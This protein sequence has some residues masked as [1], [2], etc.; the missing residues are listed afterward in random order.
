[1]MMKELYDITVLFLRCLR[2]LKKWS[3]ILNLRKNEE[4]SGKMADPESP[5]I[6]YSPRQCIIHHAY[7]SVLHALRPSN[8]IRTN[9]GYDTGTQQKRRRYTAVFD[10]EQN[11]PQFF[12]SDP[13]KEILLHTQLIRNSERVALVT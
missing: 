7:A 3:W 1:M 11:T 5:N 10:F 4:K 8:S 2:N 9:I 6:H 12:A 13:R